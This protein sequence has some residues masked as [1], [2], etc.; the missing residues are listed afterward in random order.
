M[1][2]YLTT[3]KKGIIKENPVFFMLLGMCPVL[4]LT[5]AAEN[6]V[7][8]GLA[9]TF[10]LVCSNIVISLL[11]NLIP[12]SVRLPCF[13]VIIAGFVT[14]TSLLLKEFVPWLYDELGIFLSLIACNC[15]ILG[16]AEAF[17]RKNKVLLSAADGLGMGIGFTLALFTVGS[18]REILGF[19]TWFGLSVTPDFVDPMMIFIMPAGGFFTLGVVIAVVNKIARKRPNNISCDNCPG[20]ELCKRSMNNNEHLSNNG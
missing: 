16:R 13:I 8:M 5:A 6:A 3:L 14:L 19:G 2:T 17:A 11:R 4:A 9:T 12:P 15:I 7:G 20:K 18:I 10:V 1:K